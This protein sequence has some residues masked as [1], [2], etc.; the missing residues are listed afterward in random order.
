MGVPTPEL[1]ET[2]LE[3]VALTGLRVGVAQFVKLGGR[4]VVGFGAFLIHQR[5]EPGPDGPSRYLANTRNSQIVGALLESRMFSRTCWAW[6]GAN[7]AAK[8]VP[9]FWPSYATFQAASVWRRYSS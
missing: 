3:I 6:T 7:V 9:A 8:S 1:A 4:L 2:P 5:I